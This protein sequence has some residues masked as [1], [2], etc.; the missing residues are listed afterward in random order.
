MLIAAAMM[1]SFF[2]VI[3]LIGLWWPLGDLNPHS[4]RNWNLNPACLPFHQTAQRVVE[5]NLLYVVDLY[6]MVGSARKD[7]HQVIVIFRMLCV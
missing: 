1:S 3:L 7:W 5:I 6:Q 4:F 2:M